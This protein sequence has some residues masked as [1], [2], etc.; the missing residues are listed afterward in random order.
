MSA[1][2]LKE[3]L[4]AIAEKDR[5]CAPLTLSEAEHTILRS[6]IDVGCGAFRNDDGWTIGGTAHSDTDKDESALLDKIFSGRAM[7]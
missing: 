4:A 2:I 1:E 6:L 7:P 3:N 5:S